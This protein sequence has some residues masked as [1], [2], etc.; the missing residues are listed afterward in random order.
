MFRKLALA[1]AV[2][3]SVSLPLASFASAS[4]P[5]F[6]PVT[7]LA[8][9]LNTGGYASVEST[10]CPSAG[11]CSAGGEVYDVT[12]HSHAFVA[13]Q[14][15]G[16]WHPAQLVV[17]PA[18]TSAQSSIASI[19]CS[20]PGNCAASGY[21]RD[22]AGLDQA[23]VVNEVDGE[24]ATAIEVGAIMNPNGGASL[25]SVSCASNGN[26]SAVGWVEIDQN[27]YQ[28]I[29][30]NE[31][32]GVWGAPVE[33]A[34]GLNIDYYGYLNSVSCASVGNCT[35]GGTYTDD[36]GYEVFVISEVNG[37]WGSPYELVASLN[38]GGNGYVDQVSCATPN[39]CTLVGQLGEYFSGADQAFAVN[40]VN[41]VWGQG[42][43]LAAVLNIGQEGEANAVSCSSPGNCVVG[44]FY[45]D[46]IIVPGL[47]HAHG[48]A[49]LTLGKNLQFNKSQHQAFLAVE[50]NGTWAPAFAVA[51]ALNVGS[52]AKIESV[53]CVDAANCVATGS[54]EDV[55]NRNQLFVI[56]EVAGVW[57][58]AVP[59]LTGGAQSN[60]DGVSTAC[61]LSG[62]CVIG[63]YYGDPLAF[64]ISKQF[65]SAQFVIDPFS[66]GSYALNAKLNAQ[67]WVA[68][69]LMKV[70]GLHH[71]TVIGNTDSIDSHQF[72][73]A[74]GLHRAQAVRTQ[75]LKDLA[76]LGYHSVTLATATKG[77]TQ[78]VAS[79]KTAAGRALNRRV[80]LTL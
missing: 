7:V 56:S 59:L 51:G 41:G 31:V 15:G 21:F 2:T 12:N 6:G 52:Y 75:L 61:T 23:M 66:E 30:I 69:S 14:T 3:F 39:N 20:S 38:D 5:S 40:E 72:N 43:E 67:I 36:N 73:L 55:N 45:S 62:Y 34:T 65:S 60:A 57:G 42:H 18:V 78:F 46:Q 19:S 47:R 68:A 26:C 58:N 10:S 37:S 64:I 80:V 49:R 35:A 16:L 17:V 44:G 74:L 24:W 27:S 13:D 4:N 1:A 29:I 33:V 53:S 9:A 70:H 76:A 22:A 71:A 32:N 77:D 8:Q 54:Y 79:N 48:A 11:Y 25:N 28:S 63:G 50:T